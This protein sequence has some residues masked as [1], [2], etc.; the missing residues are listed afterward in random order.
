MALNLPRLVRMKAHGA[1]GPHPLE[2]LL[3]TLELHLNRYEGSLK[4]TGPV[5]P[6]CLMQE[7]HLGHEDLHSSQPLG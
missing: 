6:Q 4:H 2:A 3:L 5:P 1:Q 7:V